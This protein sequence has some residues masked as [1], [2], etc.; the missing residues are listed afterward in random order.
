MA[1]SSHHEIDETE[2]GNLGVD[3]VIH[4][5]FENLETSQAIKTFQTL[6][7]DLEEANLQTQVR[8]GDGASLL[9]CVRVPRDHLG[10]MIHESRVKDWLYGI[11]HELPSGNNTDAE[12]P[13][14]E[15]RSVYH[16]VSWQKHLGGA[17]ITP[18]VGKWESVASA[19][20]LHDQ[21]ANAELLRKMSRAMTLTDEDLNAIRALFG[22]KVGFYFAFIH[23]YSIFLVFPAVWGVVCWLCFGPYSI[24]CAVVNCLWG[25]VFV[26]YW[27]IRETDLSQRWN[28]M[29]VGALKANRPQYVWEKEV[30]DPITG[31]TI[32]VFSMRQQLLR[33][34]LLIP[35]VMV[36]CLVLG[37]L[38]VVT[39]AMEV[40][41]SEVYAGP[42]KGYLEFLPTVLFSLSLPT[43]TSQ[44][45]AIATRLTEYENYRT[46]DQYD[47]AQTSKTFV[48]NFI[49]AFLPTL[50]TAFV[51]V[52]FGTR[53]VPYLDV[54]QV[55]AKEFSPFY[56]DTSRFQQEVI[57]LS[58]TGQVLSF[59]EEVVLPYVKKVLWRKWRDYRLQQAQQSRPRR[60]SRLTDLLLIDAPEESGF[61]RR[62]RNEA[63]ADEYNV[64]EDIL[65]MCVQ[66]GYLALFGVAWP[67]VPLGFL[68]NNWLELRG[69][70]FK[71]TLE[72]K[73]P[74]PIRTDSI[75]PSL[76]G[77]EFLT[78]LGTLSTA[79]IVYL[80]RDGMAQVHFSSLLLALLV[81]EQAYL[82]VRFAVSTGLQK[83]GSGTLRREAAKRYAVRKS[84]LDTVG[85]TSGRSNG[86][87]RVRFSDRV[88]VFSSSRDSSRDSSPTDPVETGSAELHEETPYA[89]E[90]EAEFWTE[91]N[92][93]DVGVKLIK[94]LSG[95][96]RKNK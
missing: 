77:L 59:G 87:P 37:S 70:F 11:I 94:A 66:Y 48:M 49:T 35:F 22:E 74:P 19:F 36:A 79:A 34:L 27:K 45:T 58:V 44:L 41:I 83:L 69:D 4:Y 60:H 20:P 88:D 80:Y 9:V 8:H 63:D 71:L 75:G 26:E 73:R 50:L 55:R 33:Q 2:L 51:Y 28:V 16:A 57:Y 93:L 96:E 92:A 17:G 84:Y 72:C 53:I 86:K 39:F 14:E 90:Q 85:A 38:I 46:Q 30:Q 24:T 40:F 25:I 61:F 29:G 82:G 76:Q 7:H 68:I 23:C 78:W 3:W 47:L 52:P 6:I 5:Q 18:G 67:L 10:H 15:L 64:H 81:A 43:I 54:F 32:R 95:E 12:T 89:S 21:G 13:A 65:E 31:E 1:L 56:V 42:L 62:V 91:W